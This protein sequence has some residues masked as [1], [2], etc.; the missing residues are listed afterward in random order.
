MEQPEVS[1]DI[2]PAQFFEQFL[3]MGFAAQAQAGGATPREIELAY[4]VTGDGGGEWMLSIKD[5]AMTARCGGGDA[6]VKVTVGADDWR[7]AVLGRNGAAL[8]LLIP[9][10][11]PGRP[12]NTARVRELKGT[13]ALEL[14]R[15][16]AD[17]YR[18]EMCFNGAATPRTLMKMNLAAYL[19][20]QAGKL[21]GQEAFMAGRLKVEGDISFLM[22][23]AMLTM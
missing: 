7:D 12:D 8:A 19:D 4:Q 5:G 17:P 23:V 14:A 9:Q 13:V 20:I 15:E 10:P 22:Q 18:Q 1:E 2:T 21:N 16:G 3:P 6:H 11:R